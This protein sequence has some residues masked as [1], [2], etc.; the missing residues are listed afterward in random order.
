MKKALTTALTAALALASCAHG[1]DRPRHR[2]GPARLGETVLVGGPLVRPAKLVEDSRCPE[3]A[4]C[5][6]A[7]RAIVRVIVSGGRWSREIDL[8]L[9][10][11]V[12]VAD[13]TLT[14]VSVLP[15]KSTDRPAKPR[16]YRFGF[17]FQGGL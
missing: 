11:P 13:G 12:Q 4:R 6:W 7:G 3:N 1:T 2:E 16:D 10:K 9:G 17:T 5:V 15:E 14:L 8:T